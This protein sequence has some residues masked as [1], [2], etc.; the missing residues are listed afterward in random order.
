MAVI[1]RY[2]GISFII[3]Y[4][5]KFRT[6]SAIEMQM[7]IPC[8]LCHLH[9][10]SVMR[11]IWNILLPIRIFC[12]ANMQS[13]RADPPTRVDAESS[14][15]VFTLQFNCMH[16]ILFSPTAAVNRVYCVSSSTLKSLFHSTGLCSTMLNTPAENFRSEKLLARAQLC[17]PINHTECTAYTWN[18]N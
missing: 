18:S 6:Q 8:R 7:Y 5:V 17:D 14:I 4:R 9:N 12:A 10:C 3:S 15:I 1:Y 16:I 13:A 2:Y 11:I